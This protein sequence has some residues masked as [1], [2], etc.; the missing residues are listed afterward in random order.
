MTERRRMKPR[1]ARLDWGLNRPTR[2]AHRAWFSTRGTSR[3]GCLGAALDIATRERG[4]EVCGQWKV[5]RD[6][7]ALT[8]CGVNCKSA[9]R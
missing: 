9:V 3:V 8:R 4:R 1:A 6:A 7:A 5:D 2:V